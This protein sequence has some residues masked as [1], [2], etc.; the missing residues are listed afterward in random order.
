MGQE[1]VYQVT[2]RCIR[3]RYLELNLRPE[4]LAPMTDGASTGTS[5][6]GD[7]DEIR[8]E[9]SSKLAALLAQEILPSP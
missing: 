7:G 5:K 8:I 3:C 4:H 1:G 9:P 6:H 2:T